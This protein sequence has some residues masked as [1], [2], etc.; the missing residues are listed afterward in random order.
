MKLRNYILILTF[1]LCGIQ[2]A[3]PQNTIDS[4]IQWFSEGV[5]QFQDDYYSFVDSIDLEFAEQLAKSWELF[6]VEPALTYPKKPD[7]KEMPV[8]VPGNTTV[9]ESFIYD[10]PV[11]DDTIMFE[12]VVQKND[13][14]IYVDSF[15]VIDFFGTPVILSLIKGYETKLTRID[16]KQ[17]ADYWIQLSKTNYLTFK[18]DLL[19]KKTLLGLGPWGMYQLILKWANANYSK[20][21]E[22][23]KVIF[24]VFILNKLGYKAKIGREKTKLFVLMAFSNKIY[25]KP[26]IMAGNDRYYILTENQIIKDLKIPSYSF[27]Y[28]YATLYIDLRMRSLPKLEDNVHNVKRVFMDK[29]YTFKCNT[30][31]TDYYETFPL[32]ELEI[33]ADTPFSAIAEKSI[34]SELA[35]DMRNKNNT[36]KLK[37]LLN[38]FHHGFEYQSDEEQFGYERFFFSEET[39]LYP[40][41][42]CEDRAV[43]FC[44]MVNLLCGLNTLLI[45]YPTH[46]ASAVKI[47]EPGDAII[48]KNER[49]IVC[50]PSYF[51]ATIGR[52]MKDQD[53][54]KAKIIVVH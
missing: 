46:V 52:A 50:D 34:V 39:L 25:G 7:P 22:N 26:Y 23:E 28:D 5:Q 2:K 17:I 54:S 29:T 44:R 14:Q 27:N 9:M 48:Y 1:F 8:F 4:L 33:Y 21:Q 49:Y 16:E 36:E 6:D 51:D 18:D 43:M 11:E 12:P 32:T 42:D 35:R 13:M 19:N 38:L 20:Q 15:P 3:E 40:Y 30:N 41:S 31:L 24:I 47:N 45:D 53:T 37:F 10:E